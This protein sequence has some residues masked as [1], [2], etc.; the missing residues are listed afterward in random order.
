[1]QYTI[2]RVTQI[3]SPD[4]DWKRPE[5]NRAET[6]QVAHYPWEDSGHHP[7]TTA[8]LLYDDQRLAV[9]FRVEDRYVR[10]VARNF[11]DMVC[12]DSCVEFFAAPLPD[13]EAYFNFE[14][15]CGGTMLLHRCPSP[16]ERAAGREI[17]EVGAEDGATI[18]VAHSLPRIIDPEISDPT[19][20]TLEYQIPFT[21]FEKYFE[22]ASPS[23]GTVWRGN[24]YKC[25]DD[26]SHP[27]WGA[28][29]PVGGPAPNF[30]QP[31]YFQPLV[32][33]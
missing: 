20:W 13:S 4:A 29:A 25:G 16:E 30:H 1:M 27:H 19:V 14:V 7:P 17:E 32:F 33:A 5:W 8:R 2:H 15:N 31:A 10:A 23:P 26:T 11:Q 28:W 21:L 22:A 6:L 3:S 9:I 12:R 24:F 18:L